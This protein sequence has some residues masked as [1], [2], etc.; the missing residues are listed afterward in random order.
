MAFV[1]LPHGARRYVAEGV[2][3]QRYRRME[4]CNSGGERRR[5]DMEAERYEG[6]EARCRCRDMEAWSS[7]ALEAGC[8]RADVDA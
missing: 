5:V 3:T 7:G 6:L 1:R 2:F 4:L 8:R